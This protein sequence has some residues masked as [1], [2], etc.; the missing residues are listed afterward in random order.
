MSGADA[1]RQPI[2][3]VVVALG[4]TRASWSGI[5]P[6]ARLA[7][8]FGGELLGLFLED[9]DLLRLASLPFAQ[10]VGHA[11]APMRLDRATV[12]RALRRAE[13]DAR[14]R[15]DRAAAGQG[16]RASFRVV[17]GSPSAALRA[18]LEPGDL[19]VLVQEDL[20]RLLAPALACAGVSV[21]CLAAGAARATSVTVLL[22]PRGPVR[23][24]LELSAR[25]AEAAGAELVVLVP[26]SASSS[27]EEEAAAV[28]A[29]VGGVARLRRVLGRG[30]L[31]DVVGEAPGTVIACSRE[32]FAASESSRGRWLALARR[33]SV[34]ILC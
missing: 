30:P 29:E 21:L 14:A 11:P 13:A 5:E 26:A 6:A 3:R 2:R 19:V 8:R 33:R 25:V 7:R 10:V 16:V 15:L 23:P 4:P 12:E 9:E 27:L 28:L 1:R 32:L 22:E 24:Q 31:P 34:L 20:D 17:R 18:T